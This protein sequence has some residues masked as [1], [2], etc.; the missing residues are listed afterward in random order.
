MRFLAT[1][2]TDRVFA[3]WTTASTPYAS[4]PSCASG[5]TP[6]GL[7]PAIPQSK[8]G[9]LPASLRGF[10]QRLQCHRHRPR[11]LDF[12]GPISPRCPLV[13]LQ[14]FGGV[15][16][17]RK[18][19][20]TRWGAG[21]LQGG[22]VFGGRHVRGYSPSRAGLPSTCLPVRRPPC[23]PGCRESS[24]SARPWRAH[25]PPSCSRPSARR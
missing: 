24:A 16:I 9:G 4:P 8:C 19:A 14:Q 15:A 12:P 3:H 1:P 17:Q 6:A 18:Q 25:L 2:V 20:G 11:Y 7:E 10:V 21:L 5:I 23:G 13:D 22:A